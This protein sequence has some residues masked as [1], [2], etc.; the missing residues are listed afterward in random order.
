MI[1]P[2]CYGIRDKIHIYFQA[3]LR[4]RNENKILRKERISKQI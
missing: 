3:I 4:K 1:N 2:T